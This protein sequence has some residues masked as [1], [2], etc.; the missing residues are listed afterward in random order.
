[1]Y[2]TIHIIRMTNI[3][4]NKCSSFGRSYYYNLWNMLSFYEITWLI[5]QN[6]DKYITNIDVSVAKSV[7]Q[8]DQ[9]YEWQIKICDKLFSCKIHNVLVSE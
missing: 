7:K 2:I 8:D 9:I 6:N 3:Y 1:M 5:T 4:K